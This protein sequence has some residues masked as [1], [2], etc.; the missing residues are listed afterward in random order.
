M[1]FVFV[2]GTL[3]RSFCGIS[4][5]FVGEGLTLTQHQM[6]FRGFP[7]VIDVVEHPEKVKEG[8][9]GH[10]KGEVFKVSKGVL[11]DLDSYEGYPTFYT[12]RVTPIL[13]LTEDGE[14]PTI[15][16]WMYYPVDALSGWDAATMVVPTVDEELV[17]P[18][19]LEKM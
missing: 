5:D 14:E 19:N 16:C 8:Y 6:G 2:Y 1:E 15:N 10:V 9:S 4:G 13:I 18:D 12:R 3:K 11:S 17:W 7:R